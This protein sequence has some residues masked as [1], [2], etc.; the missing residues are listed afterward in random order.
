MGDGKKAKALLDSWCERL[1][2]LDQHLGRQSVKLCLY[3]IVLYV[4][5]AQDS[6]NSTVLNE[7]D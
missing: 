7:I 5:K 1:D 4:D 2:F 3:C 6:Y